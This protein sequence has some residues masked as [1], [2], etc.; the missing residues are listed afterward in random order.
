[1]KNLNWILHAIALVA[2][3]YLFSQ[4]M[5][6]KK[7]LVPVTTETKMEAASTGTSRIA[8]FVSDTLLSQLGFFKKSEEEFKKKQER[9][10]GELRA[11]ESS[12]QKEIQALQSNAQNL[13]RNE[14]E[15]G[16]K[17]LA[18]LEQDLMERKETLSQQ[19][20][21]ETADFNEKLH[22]KVISYLKEINADHKYSYVFSVARDG[23]IFYADS[24]YDITASMVKDLNE[25][26]S[27]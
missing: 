23:N 3:V 2:I 11:K 15:S 4:N 1:M 6:L 8:Y 21:E 5:N 12:F 18:K 7:S 13:T 24:A 17:R 14:L 20:A 27:K 22:Q 10:T 26:Y 9:A 25:K 16:Q 19:F